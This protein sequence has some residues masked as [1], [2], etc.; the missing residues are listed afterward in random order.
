MKLIDVF[1]FFSGNFWILI[2]FTCLENKSH[3]VNQL[4]LRIYIN[5]EKINHKKLVGINNVSMC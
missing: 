4:C 2:F 5:F 1:D 3:Y